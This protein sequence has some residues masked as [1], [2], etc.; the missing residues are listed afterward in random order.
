M[1]N[2]SCQKG[3]Q[4]GVKLV[5][6]LSSHEVEVVGLIF[7]KPGCQ[8]REISAHSQLPL[9]RQLRAKRCAHSAPMLPTRSCRPSFPATKREA[10]AQ[11]RLLKSA[12]VENYL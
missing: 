7:L 3:N 10:V 11:L 12:S 1:V 4:R 2:G 9:L 6:R 5:F 8:L